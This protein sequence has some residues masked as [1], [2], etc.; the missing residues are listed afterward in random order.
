MKAV[1]SLQYYF[2]TN[3]H[4]HTMMCKLVHCRGEKSMNCFSTNPGVFFGLLRTSIPIIPA[5][6]PFEFKF[7]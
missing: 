3:I 7:W 4:E 5:D 1:V 2:W 6:M